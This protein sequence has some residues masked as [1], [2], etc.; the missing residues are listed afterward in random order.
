ML[1]TVVLEKTLESARRSNQSILK[2]ISPEYFIGRTDAEA[3]T[4][5]L[6]PPDAK[7]WFICKDPNAGSGLEELPHA[8][9]QGQQPGGAPPGPREV[10]A[11]AQEGGE[12][13]LHVQGQE[14][15]LWGDTPRPR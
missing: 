14:G 15:R 12:E 2:G 4:P 8:W 1:W 9:G 5:I 13:L 10:A 6:Y 7:S 11:W 3:E